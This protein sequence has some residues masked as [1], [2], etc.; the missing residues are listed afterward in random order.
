MNRL[1]ARDSGAQWLAENAAVFLNGCIT[2]MKRT[3]L[4]LVA[5]LILTD[6]ASALPPMQHLAQGSITTI[7]DAEIVLALTKVGKD[8]PA[9]FAIK[10][11]RTRFRENGKKA[12][13][14]NLKAG[15]SVRIYY[16]KEMG[17]WVATEVAWKAAPPSQTGFST[18]QPPAVRK[19]VR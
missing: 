16:R 7:D 12:S 9:V 8:T 6:V 17:M 10:L 15:Q 1:R 5:S 18:A 14:E 19:Q 4:F 3:L 2:T 13:L 11:G